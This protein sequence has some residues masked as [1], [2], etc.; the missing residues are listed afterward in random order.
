MLVGFTNDS[1][2]VEIETTYL[3]GVTI[4]MLT[5]TIGF[6]FKLWNKLCKVAR[7]VRRIHPE[8]AELER[9]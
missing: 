5:W 8:E 7:V 3:I 9:L 6:Q 2:M 4:A 1:K